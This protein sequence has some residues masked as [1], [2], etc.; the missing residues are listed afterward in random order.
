MLTDNQ[1]DILLSGFIQISASI[2][3][4]DFATFMK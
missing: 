1:T 4:N 3:T 2:P